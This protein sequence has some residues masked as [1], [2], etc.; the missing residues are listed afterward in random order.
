MDQ[1]T[2]APATALDQR[3]AQPLEHRDRGIGVAV[4]GDVDSSTG[5]VRESNIMGWADVHAVPSPFS[6]RCLPGTFASSV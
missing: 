6:Q 5:I 2:V 1:V 4:S 3:G